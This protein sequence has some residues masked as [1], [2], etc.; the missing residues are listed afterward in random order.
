MIKGE[1]ARYEQFLLFPQCFQKTCIG[2]TCL[3]K[4]YGEQ[5]CQVIFNPFPNMTWFLRVCSTSLLKTQREKEKL[6]IK[7]EIAQC[8]L[9]IWLTLCYFHQIYYCC[10]QTLSVWKSL[11]FDVWE[12]LNTFINTEEVMVWTNSKVKKKAHL[13]QKY[14][15][16]YL[17]L[18]YRGKLIIC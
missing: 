16:C 1:I 11:K 3:G 10:L 6:L 4:G 17:P 2:N 7:G 13:C 9:P 12:R 15:D 5:L 14:F 8:F 18:L